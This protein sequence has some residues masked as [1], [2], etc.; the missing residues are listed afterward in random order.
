MTTL[1]DT[2]P[3]QRAQC[4]GMWCYIFDQAGEPPI[5]EGIIAGC[6]ESDDG[7]SLVVIDHP[8]QDAGK[9]GHELNEVSPRP[10]LPRAW[11]PDGTPVSAKREYQLAHENGKVAQPV[12]VPS[13]ERGKGYIQHLEA[14]GLS[15]SK[16]MRVMQ[17]HV[18]D[19]EPLGEA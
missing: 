12:P 15:A 2:T 1:A 9:W 11:N 13:V 14:A 16:G 19:W 7:R 5:G 8:H 17:R 3:E 6:K 18:T 4:V 10:D